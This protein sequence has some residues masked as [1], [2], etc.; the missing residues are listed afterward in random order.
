MAC[1][2]KVPGSYIPHDL[3]VLRIAK[4]QA[5]KFPWIDAWVKF[6]HPTMQEESLLRFDVKEFTSLLDTLV[7]IPGIGG[8]RIYFAS[9]NKNGTVTDPILPKGKEDLLTVI[10]ASTDG[11]GLDTG[12]YFNVDYTSSTTKPYLKDLTQAQS[13]DWVKYFQDNKLYLLQQEGKK[14]NPA[15]LETRSIW[16]AINHITDWKCI[17]ECSNEPGMTPIIF[18]QLAFA[19]YID[20]DNWPNQLSFVIQMM[21]SGPT[22]PVVLNLENLPWFQQ[23]LTKLKRY[24]DY[25]TGSP[26]PPSPGCPT[27]SSLP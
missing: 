19:A 20:T 12:K 21:G 11:K 18:V 15:F 23:E 22:G 24:D 4:F 2:C 7:A 27:N 3:A 1:P 14:T 9:Y 10:F 5:N 26:C 6:K 13:S 8:V 16:F 17:I 25:D